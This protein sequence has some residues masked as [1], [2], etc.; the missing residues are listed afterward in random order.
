[1][2]IIVKGK[3]YRMIEIA[4]EEVQQKRLQGESFL[5]VKEEDTLYYTPINRAVYCRQLRKDA[6]HLCERCSKFFDCEK[7]QARDI[8]PESIIGKSKAIENFEF[9]KQG[10]EFVNSSA[11]IFV[12]Y[13]CTNF[14]PE[15]KRRITTF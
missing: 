9:I 1:M 3:K 8:S 5:L 4:R 7:V 13:K 14:Q 10:Y 11:E 15:P 6:V 12:V 2:E